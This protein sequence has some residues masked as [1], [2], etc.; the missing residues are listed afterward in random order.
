MLKSWDR[1]F[2]KENKQV[3]GAVKGAYEF[4]KIEE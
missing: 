1:G 3:W 2:N 4:I